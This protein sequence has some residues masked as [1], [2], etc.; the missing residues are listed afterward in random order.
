V[1][2]LGIT[3]FILGLLAVVIGFNENALA[4]TAILISGA[5]FVAGGVI[6]LAIGVAVATL[7]R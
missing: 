3:L 4:G 6:T 2:A 5:V 1:P 7:R